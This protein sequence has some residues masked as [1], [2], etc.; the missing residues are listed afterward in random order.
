MRNGVL[1]T[2]LIM[3]RTLKLVSFPPSTWSHTQ[4][5]DKP[6]LQAWIVMNIWAMQSSTVSLLL[7][8]KWPRSSGHGPLHCLGAEGAAMKIFLCITQLS[9]S[10]PQRCAGVWSPA[11]LP[12]HRAVR[13][14]D[15]AGSIS[16][17]WQAQIILLPWLFVTISFC[18][19]HV[20][21]SLIDTQGDAPASNV[22]AFNDPSVSHKVSPAFSLWN[23]PHAGSDWQIQGVTQ[24]LSCHSADS[25]H[26]YEP[27]SKVGG[28]FTVGVIR[29]W[30]RP[31][32]ETNF[33]HVKNNKTH[34]FF[35][36][37]VLNFPN[38]QHFLH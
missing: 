12:P 4:L 3:P 35:W 24:P 30:T 11:P 9:C 7:L 29:L 2:H 22:P 19:E 37:P 36:W 28:T 6:S 13:L 5:L 16:I 21:F 34:H 27:I 38:C 20:M 1:F 25:A 32:G 14:Q 23:K 33:S 8:E 15:G 17:T 31:S 18:M 10:T 26:Y